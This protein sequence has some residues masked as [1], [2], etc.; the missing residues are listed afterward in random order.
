[1]PCDHGKP[2]FIKTTEISY[3]YLRTLSYQIAFWKIKQSKIYYLPVL[4]QNIPLFIIQ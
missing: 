4:D 1:M 3:I 2:E